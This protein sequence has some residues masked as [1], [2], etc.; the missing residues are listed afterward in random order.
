MWTQTNRR[1]RTHL[2]KKNNGNPKKVLLER[3]TF[4]IFLQ[5]IRFDAYV[6][7]IIQ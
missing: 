5:I 3:S 7:R 2:R 6:N 4:F 1:I